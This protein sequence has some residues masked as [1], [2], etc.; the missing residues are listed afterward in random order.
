MPTRE[1]V[2]AHDPAATRGPVAYRPFED[3]DLSQVAELFRAQWCSG[4]EPHVGVIASRATVCNYLADAGWGVVAERSGRVLG[5]ALVACG[6]RDSE[7]RAAWLAR[8]DELVAQ[9][10]PDARFGVEVG[11]VEA[12]EGRLSRRYV[13]EASASPAEAAFSG[14]EIKLLIVSPAAQGLG[15]GRSLMDAVTRHMRNAG[16]HGLF[17]ITD[18]TCDVGFYDHMGLSRRLEQPSE[19][20]PGISLYVYGRDLA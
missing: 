12:E 7:T 6:A 2:A 19:A 13:R 16:R 3:R 14:A 20:D 15:V 10:G 9:V 1:P 5:V 17:L 8:R 11:P 4:L 18:D